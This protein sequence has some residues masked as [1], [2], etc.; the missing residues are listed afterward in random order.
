MSDV[1]CGDWMQTASGRRFYPLDPRPEEVHLEDIAAA[2]SRL[3]RFGGHCRAFYSIA[4]H[5]VLVSLACAPEDALA[6]LLHDAAEAYV[7]DMIRPLKRHP[8]LRAYCNIEEEIR[9]A[10][11][12]RFRLGRAGAPWE[13]RFALPASVKHADEVLLA[14]EARD[15]MGHGCMETW[16]T[17]KLAEPLPRP[18]VPWG[19]EEARD[20]FLVRFAA[21]QEASP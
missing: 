20:R 2:L 6:G 7:G 21:L 19:P 3:C 14:T 4:Q 10:I 15:L 17:W 18:I 8:N 11:W 5:S 13:D 16:T 9:A 12:W 1:R